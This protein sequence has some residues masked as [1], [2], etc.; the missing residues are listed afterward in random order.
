VDDLRFAWWCLFVGL[1]LVS[2]SATRHWIAKL[3]LSAS[4]VYLL[5]GF[6]LGPA[7][8]DVLEVDLDGAAPW[9]E[10]LSEVAV[11]VSLFVAGFKL[12]QP[13]PAGR[14]RVPVRLASLSM[15]VTVA[16][17][18]AAAFFLLGLPIGPSILLGAIL[19]PTDPVLASDVQ[20]AHP[21]DRDALRFSLT[22]EG[23]LNDGTAFPFVMLGL[24][25]M[26]VHELG[27]WGARWWLVDVLW[28]VGGGLGIGFALGHLV[29][30]LAL[31]LGRQPRESLLA[32]EFI[33]L[34]LVALAYGAT[35]LA[36]AYGFLAVFAA[37]FAL[38]RVAHPPAALSDTR[39]AEGVP[40][41]AALASV[42]HF[43]EQV[44]RFAEMTIVLVIGALA[45][46]LAYRLEVLWFVPLAFL[47]VRPLAVAVG[48]L[49]TS[50]GR[51]RASLMAWFGIRGAGSIYYLMFAITHGIDGPVA[52]R[53]AGIVLA[54]VVTSIV[55]H[56][57]S[58][59]P[60]MAWYERRKAAR[61]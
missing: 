10:R 19:A 61:S 50:T 47:L 34:G 44:E 3:P 57:I 55:L 4:L 17:I 12:G 11:L 51:T 37:G 42:Q 20:L 33:A 36:H 6:V 26:G 59:T 27:P 40:P 13:G 58:V 9:L 22:G 30:R 32:H 54:T 24:G 25:L 21:G 35:L 53:L 2:V 38:R 31:W 5:A 7:A 45:G 56:G 15:V 29:G 1:L 46:H 41:H 16:L 60:L 43:N 39:T 8:L 23:A 14:W 52:E 28:A 49:G 18:A 48:T